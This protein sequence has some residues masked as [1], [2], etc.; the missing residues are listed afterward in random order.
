MRAHRRLLNHHAVLKLSL[1][2][3]LHLLEIA[4]RVGVVQAFCNLALSE[5]F[6]DSIDVT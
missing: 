3:V 2:R 6:E 5:E 1:M 4:E